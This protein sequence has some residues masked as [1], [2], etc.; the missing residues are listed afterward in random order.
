MSENTAPESAPEV[1]DYDAEIAAALADLEAADSAASEAQEK[2]NELHE[3]AEVIA[4]R[5]RELK[6]LQAAQSATAPVAQEVPAAP[7]VVREWR[8]S[9]ASYL[10]SVV[11]AKTEE[12]AAREFAACHIT[13]GNLCPIGKGIA[14]SDVS[15]DFIISHPDE[16]S[17]CITVEA[18]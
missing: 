8:V 10:P 16:G 14:C 12:E 3:N 18:A 1:R 2:A 4:L 11:R 7:S 15:T 17:K 9:G 6:G 5:I 13:G